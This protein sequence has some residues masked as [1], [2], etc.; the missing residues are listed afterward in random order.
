MKLI[1]SILGILKNYDIQE[2]RIEWVG[3]HELFGVSWEEFKKKA[4]DTELGPSLNPSLVITGDTWFIRITDHDGLTG[5]ELELIEI[6]VPG[7]LKPVDLETILN[8]D[9]R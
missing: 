4:P 6:P 3:I 1:D 9:P 8:V 2:S 7:N 5:P